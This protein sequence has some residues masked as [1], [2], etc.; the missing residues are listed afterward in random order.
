M[1]N[2][3]CAVTSVIYKKMLI[4]NSPKFVC[5]NRCEIYQNC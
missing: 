1:Y 4:K 3:Y 2:W 5:I